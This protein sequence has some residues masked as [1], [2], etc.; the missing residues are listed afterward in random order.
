[1]EYYDVILGLIPVVFG[2][3]AGGF[4][5]IG[6]GL[7]VAIPFGGLGAI[8]LMDH[9]MFVHGSTDASTQSTPPIATSTDTPAMDIAD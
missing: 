9:A 3:V 7:M 8:A 6:F 5:A 1:M 4:L 2:G